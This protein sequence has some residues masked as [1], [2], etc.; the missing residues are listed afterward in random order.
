MKTINTHYIDGSFVESHG[1]E[2]MDI[3]KPTNGQLIGRVTLADEEDTRR[4]LQ[5][6]I[7]R[8][9]GLASQPRKSVRR[10]YSGCMRRRRRVSTI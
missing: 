8:L 9:S 7:V 10:S 6:P 1:R 3:I 5:Q 4:L 2:V